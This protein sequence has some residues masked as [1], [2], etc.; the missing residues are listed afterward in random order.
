MEERFRRA[1]KTFRFLCIYRTDNVIIVGCTAP[2]S[3]CL[4][5]SRSRGTVPGNGV[6]PAFVERRPINK[7]LSHGRM[8]VVVGAS[9]NRNRFFGLCHLQ[10]I[11]NIVHREQTNIS[12]T[13]HIQFFVSCLRVIPLFDLLCI[14]SFLSLRSSQTSFFFGQS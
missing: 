4:S 10:M 14:S 11:T 6:S 9:R 12:K 5:Y 7:P 3:I 13:L 8:R 1:A 2:Y